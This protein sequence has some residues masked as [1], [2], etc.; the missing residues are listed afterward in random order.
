MTL[1]PQTLPA[2]HWLFTSPDAFQKVAYFGEKR[3][4]E[5]L[6]PHNGSGGFPP[7]GLPSRTGF[8]SQSHRD[9]ILT[10]ADPDLAQRGPCEQGNG[11]YRQTIS[12]AAIVNACRFMVTPPC[13]AA[14]KRLTFRCWFGRESLTLMNNQVGLFTACRSRQTNQSCAQDSQSQAPTLILSSRHKPRLFPV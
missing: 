3:V 10:I 7:A 12:T 4:P 6:S 9:F 13:F 8:V 1:H 5:S 2:V 14:V 11:H